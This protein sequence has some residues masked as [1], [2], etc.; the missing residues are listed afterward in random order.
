MGQARGYF[1]L[2]LVLGRLG[3]IENMQIELPVKNI[4]IKK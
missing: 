3:K 4:K 2:I 1:K